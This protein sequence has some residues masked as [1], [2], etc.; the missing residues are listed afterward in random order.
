[1][2]AV[3]APELLTPQARSAL[4]ERN[5]SVLVS[6]ISCAELACAVERG[7]IAI[8]RHWKVWFRHFVEA[9]QWQVAS[10]DLPVVEEAYS[11]PPPV[12]QDPADRII[13]ATARIHRAHVVTGDRKILEY[14]HVECCWG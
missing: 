5:N 14:P 11:L 6:A 12:H 7:R 8:D 10:I 13:I 1:M 9:N 3:S 2:W 4:T